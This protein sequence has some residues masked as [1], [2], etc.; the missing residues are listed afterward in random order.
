M[1]LSGA[2]LFGVLLF[3]GLARYFFGVKIKLF[4]RCFV[5]EN[6]YNYFCSLGSGHY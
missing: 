3:F 6:V 4:G 5:R 2:F 1:D